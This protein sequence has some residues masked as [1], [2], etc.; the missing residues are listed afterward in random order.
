MKYLRNGSIAFLVLLLSTF[1]FATERHKS[2]AL[3][4]NATVEG[5]QLKA[6]NYNLKWDDSQKTTNVNFEQNGKTVLTAP[7]QVVHTSNPE[8][9]NFEVNTASGQPQLRRVY[10]SQEQL[11]FGNENSANGNSTTPPSQ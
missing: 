8:N 5:Q 2:V 3:T 7:A 6:G 10:L 9:A 11:V 1:S 4:Q